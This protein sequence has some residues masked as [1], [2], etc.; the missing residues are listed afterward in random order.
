MSHCGD[1]NTSCKQRSR[2]CNNT[3]A[4][5]DH[6]TYNRQKD[7]LLQGKCYSERINRWAITDIDGGYSLILPDRAETLII[8]F[9][10]YISQ[11]I[12]I[13]NASTINATLV[14]D[15]QSLSEVVVVGY[16]SQRKSDITGSVSSVK[17]PDLVQLPSIRSD[18]ALQGRAAG[19]V[20]TNND[21]A[22]GGAATIRIRGGNSITGSNDAL[23][24]IDGFQG[25]D[26][27]SLNPNE[28]ESIEVLKDASAT[29]IYGSKGANGV[30]LVTTKRGKTG[31]PIID[32][33]YSY[34]AQSF[35]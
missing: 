15:T 32:Y 34:G 8:S 9:V 10:G 3:C 18:E 24:V 35:V 25:G 11:E 20:V 29:A 2:T 6:R 33:S 17:G 28:V 5:E 31:A 27:S 12:N 16:G 22:P 19:V 30:I 23:V 1:R 26:L 21:G 13:G 14:P 7:Y 4:E